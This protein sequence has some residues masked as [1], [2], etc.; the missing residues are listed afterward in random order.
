MAEPDPWAVT[1]PAAGR[2][3]AVGVRVPSDEVASPVM[4]LRES[5]VRANVGTMARYC[6]DVG[7]QLAPHG[8]TTMSPQLLRLQLAA[9][10]WG[11]TV[12]T[13]PQLRACLDMG[14]RRILLANQL[15][16]PATIR[17]A[18]EAMRGPAPV[19]LTCFVDSVDG[20][21]L[22]QRELG[23]SGADGGAVDV[24]VELGIP[25][26]RTGCRD[27]GHAME[28]ARAAAAA[29]ALRVIGTAGYEGVVAGDRCPG[30]LAAVRAY[31]AAL[32]DLTGELVASGLVPSGRRPVI[33]AGGSAYFDV[34]VDVLAGRRIGGR[35]AEVVMRSGAYVSH[36]HG[37]YRRLSPFEQPGSRYG[38]RPA[39]QIWGRVLSVPE[40]GLALVDFG[41]RD[42]PFDQDLPVPLERRDPRGQAAAPANLLAVTA[43][44]DQHAFVDVRADPS[45]RPGDWLGCGIS[46]PCTAF[47]KW[48]V[49]PVVDDD[50]VVVGGI[51][52]FF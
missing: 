33:S 44:N 4:A 18:A 41:R 26:G 23:A 21:R 39:L 12:A 19:E 11:V 9:G 37:L 43:L 2:L 31:C 5:A 13:G 30:A 29:P 34:V 47:D 35:N 17:S 7:V 20:V 22:L 25:G 32:A 28:V 45:L 46:H 42:V 15:V 16:D 10:A 3:P 51:E 27:A 40:P 6:R 49:M 36:D 24:L 48:R 50:D 52:T 1:G 38:L 14:I 8:K